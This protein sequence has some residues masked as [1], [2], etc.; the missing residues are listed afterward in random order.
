[1]TGLGDAG[2]ASPRMPLPSVPWRGARRAPRG[3][4]PKAGPTVPDGVELFTLAGTEAVEG[5]GAA[6]A[7]VPVS[8]GNTRSCFLIF[9][10]LK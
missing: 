3:P 9:S 4:H 10:F 8:G 2:L 5:G 6:A 7:G 1:M